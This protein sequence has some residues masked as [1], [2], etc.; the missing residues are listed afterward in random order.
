MWPS[1]CWRDATLSP[2][3]THGHCWQIYSQC[4]CMPCYF[5]KLIYS[6]RRDAARGPD[7]VCLYTDTL[8]WISTPPLSDTSITTPS[9]QPSL[10]RFSHQLCQH[11]ARVCITALFTRRLLSD[12]GGVK[13]QDT[14][15]IWNLPGLAVN[16]CAAFFC[17]FTCKNLLSSTSDCSGRESTGQNRRAENSFW[18]CSK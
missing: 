3:S 4:Q 7:L 12:A 17:S 10:H 1:Y 8:T 5:I 16:L 9:P 14:F 6:V 11:M 13:P 2:C 18:V 15:A